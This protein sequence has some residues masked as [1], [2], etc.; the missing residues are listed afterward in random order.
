MQLVVQQMINRGAPPVDMPSMDPPP[1]AWYELGTRILKIRDLQ[2]SVIGTQRK[3]THTHTQTHIRTHAHTRT[4]THTHTHTH[5]THTQH[6]QHTHTHTRLY[7][8]TQAHLQ[9]RCRFRT[10]GRR[11]RSTGL[12]QGLH[13][14]R[15]HPLVVDKEAAGEVRRRTQS[16]YLVLILTTY[17]STCYLL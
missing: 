11:N 4:H 15:R 7:I 13:G 3:H 1:P 14:P 10:D 6:T 17:R 16:T 12:L 9:T 8:H 5:S 2:R